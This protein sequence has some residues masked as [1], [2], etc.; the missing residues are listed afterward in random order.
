MLALSS[1]A[2][3]TDEVAVVVKVPASKKASVVSN[4]VHFWTCQ[5]CEPVLVISLPMTD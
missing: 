2:T 3:D 5:E 1:T 4:F